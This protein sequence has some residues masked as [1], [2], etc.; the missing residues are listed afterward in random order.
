MDMIECWQGTLCVREGLDVVAQC[1]QA[2]VA[3][4]LLSYPPGWAGPHDEVRA[5]GSACPAN[6]F[7]SRDVSVTDG[8][9]VSEPR[10]AGSQLP[11]SLLYPHV[12]TM[13]PES[14]IIQALSSLSVS[15]IHHDRF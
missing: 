12:S 11:T 7:L 5:I 3:R 1:K 6:T 10:M 2:A 8:A 9:M 14:I 13:N 4:D 15:S